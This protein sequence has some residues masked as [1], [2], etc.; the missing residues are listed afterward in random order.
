[1]V[2]LQCAARRGVSTIEYTDQ[3][4][5]LVFLQMAHER[6]TRPLK[7]QRMVPP[8]YSW[9]RLLDAYDEDLETT[10]RHILEQL[11]RQSGTLGVVLRKAPNRIQDPAKLKRLVVDWI[12]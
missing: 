8:E 2:V 5:Y 1:V 12:D 3:L 11:G 6:A 10:Y 7:P 4:S 9:Q